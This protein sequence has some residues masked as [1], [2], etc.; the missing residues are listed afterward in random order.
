M[1]LPL[2]FN[3][4]TFCKITK[5]Q[6]TD[7]LDI[8]K[9]IRTRS[10]MIFNKLCDNFAIYVKNKFLDYD[11]YYDAKDES[12]ENIRFYDY[13]FVNIL[14]IICQ[15][16]IKTFTKDLYK[17]NVL[18][19]CQIF[20]HIVPPYISNYYPNNDIDYNMLESIKYFELFEP[21]VLESIYN[22]YK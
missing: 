3:S 22:K 10:I 21:I 5:Y 9:I 16:D 8:E 14:Y 11:Y 18:K 19:V 7:K 1:T 15:F 20:C 6:A 2:L 17:L 12:I 13:C 4:R